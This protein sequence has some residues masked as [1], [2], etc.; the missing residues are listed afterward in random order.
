MPMTRSRHRSAWSGLSLSVGAAALAVAFTGCG[1]GTLNGGSGAGGTAGTAGTGG[2]DVQPQDPP[3]K[4]EEEQLRKL[5]DGSGN[6]DCAKYRQLA[7][8]AAAELWNY[9]LGPTS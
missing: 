1:E 6:V 8:G 5:L 3:G 9:R 2:T 4:T 7:A